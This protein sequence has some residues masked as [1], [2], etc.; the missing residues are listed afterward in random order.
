MIVYKA[1]LYHCRARVH[2]QGSY[3]QWQLTPIEI[4]HECNVGVYIHAVGSAC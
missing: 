3:K 4:A 1:I 2:L